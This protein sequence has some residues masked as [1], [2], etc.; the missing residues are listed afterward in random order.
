MTWKDIQPDE[1]KAGDYININGT[2]TPIVEANQ[3]RVS[4]EAAGAISSIDL[5]V[6]ITLGVKFAREIED[7]PYG[8]IPTERGAVIRIGK[9]VYEHYKGGW[10]RIGVG[11][12]SHHEAIQDRA[13]RHGFE[14][15]W[16]K[17]SAE[18]TDEMV[19]RACLAFADH[20]YGPD[21]PRRIAMIR[22]A[23]MCAALEAALGVDE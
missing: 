13:D 4:Y 15:L 17:P 21:V 16:P 2:H 12:V 20:S 1:V 8:L 14:V 23:S 6:A 18:I 10:R 19:E 9:C 3:F 22:S 5:Q 11:G 7:H